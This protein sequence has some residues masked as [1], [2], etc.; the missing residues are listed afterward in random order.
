MRAGHWTRAVA[1]TEQ[2]RPSETGAF[3]FYESDRGFRNKRGV[4]RPEAIF[5]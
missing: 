5:D 1:G 4:L 2:R 3:L